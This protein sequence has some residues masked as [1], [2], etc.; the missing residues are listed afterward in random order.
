MEKIILNAALNKA[1]HFIAQKRN[2]MD[3]FV[4][5][6]YFVFCS[7]TS[8]PDPGRIGWILFHQNYEISQSVTFP[9][10]ETKKSPNYSEELQ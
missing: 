4:F 7:V 8:V 6:T 9:K 10:K 1:K 3:N 2:V 5:Y